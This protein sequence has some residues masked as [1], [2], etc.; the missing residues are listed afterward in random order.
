MKTKWIKIFDCDS[1]KCYKSEGKP[2]IE[3]HKTFGAGPY[4]VKSNGDLKRFWTLKEAKE[5]VEK[6]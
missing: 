2:N 4:T 3:Y 6:L 1:Y 5:F